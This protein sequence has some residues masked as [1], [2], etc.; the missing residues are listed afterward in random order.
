MCVQACLVLGPAQVMDV[1]RHQLVRVVA[2]GLPNRAVNISGPPSAVVLT[3]RLLTLLLAFELRCSSCI[4]LA[5]RQQPAASW[6]SQVQSTSCW[7]PAGGLAVKKIRAGTRFGAATTALGTSLACLTGS[8]SSALPAKTCQ[9]RAV[10]PL[11]RAVLA[12][13]LLSLRSLQPYPAPN[14]PE[15]PSESLLS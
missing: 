11:W 3:I 8:M 5:V 6:R 15:G 2:L 1:H 12:E 10:M 14:T 4:A 13:K 9:Q 7:W